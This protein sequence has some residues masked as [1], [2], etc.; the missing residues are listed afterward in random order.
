MASASVRS[1]WNLSWICSCKGDWRSGQDGEC[2]ETKVLE[3]CIV[4]GL[5]A[6]H[7]INHIFTYFHGRAERLRVT[8]QDI[9]E[10][11][12]ESIHI[13]Q[14][15]NSAW[16]HERNALSV[17]GAEHALGNKCDYKESGIGCE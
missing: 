4:R 15:R 2:C 11:D 6:A 12:C 14:E 9:T 16:Y 1:N 7:A 8:A 17:E 13:S 5:R 3:T 10:V